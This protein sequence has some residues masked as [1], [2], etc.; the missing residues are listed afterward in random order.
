M[1][2]TIVERVANNVRDNFIENEIGPVL[3]ILRES[4]R[5]KPFIQLRESFLQSKEGTW[6]D[7][8]S[9]I[10]RGLGRH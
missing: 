10:V 8:I 7:E 1:L 5:R 4:R 2:L 6:N 9:I 3:G